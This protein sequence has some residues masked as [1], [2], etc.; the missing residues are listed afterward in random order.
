VHLLLGADEPPYD[1]GVLTPSAAPLP[2]APAIRDAALVALRADRFDR[3][4][5]VLFAVRCCLLSGLLLASLEPALARSLGLVGPAAPAVLGGLALSTA[6]SRLLLAGSLGRLATF[7]SLC[8]DAAA[9][10]QLLL[11]TG[12]LFSPLVGT[13]LVLLAATALL[14]RHPATAA[15]AL[16]VLPAAAGLHGPTQVEPADLFL[17][18][19]YGALGLLALAA[20][21]WL[22][23]RDE[24]AHLA[25]A[26]LEEAGRQRAVLEERARL[27]RE[28]HDGVGAALST[29]VLQ[30][31]L[32]GTRVSAGNASGEIAG[33]RDT[34]EEAIEELR[35]SVRLLRDDFE[36]GRAVDEHCRRFAART[37]LDVRCTIAGPGARLGGPQQLALFRVLQESLQN[38]A[39][40]ARATTV[41][42]DL[43]LLPEGALLHVRDDGVGFAAGAPAP[44][45]HYGLR[46]MRERATGCGGRLEVRSEPGSGTSIDLFLPAPARATVPGR[47]AR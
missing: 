43:Q 23:G 25:A 33:L 4:A 22:Q 40:H 31:E 35:R 28:I 26:A 39:R 8:L 32:A 45:G 14:F 10:A 46:G 1:R 34:A 9:L 21:R 7:A 42:V 37:G 36:P 41:T 27:S 38:A 16:L 30:A 44:A 47:S 12:G 24:E 5:R 17:L 6:A 13:Q 15:P 20:L 18:G 19:W 11:A 3:R 2:L 29:L